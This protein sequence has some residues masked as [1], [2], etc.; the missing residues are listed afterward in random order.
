[1][2]DQRGKNR[3]LNNRGKIAINRQIRATE[4]R[5]ITADGQQAGVVSLIDALEQAEH[6]GLDLVEVSPQANPPVCKIMDFGKYLFEQ[7][8][9]VKNRAKRVQI[10]E[11]K[12]R[13]VTDVGDYLVKTKRAAEFLQNGD[14]VRF[15]VRFR[16]RELS[17]QQHGHDILAR[18]AEDL[19]E[20]GMV[21]QN[22][23]IEGKQMVMVLVPNKKN[24]GN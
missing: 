11:L 7:R 4:V 3:D 2:Y 19:K 16:G 17:Y 14:K 18:V 13:P 20:H 6:S 22:A 24:K 9:K 5:L 10:K 15:V 1:M 23:K 12:L 21:E 8:K